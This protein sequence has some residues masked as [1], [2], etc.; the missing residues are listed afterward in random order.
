[1]LQ[2]EQRK[3]AAVLAADV[4]EYSRL[5]GRDEAGTHAR[6]KEHAAQ[7]LEPALARNGGRLVKTTG[8]GFFAEFP[9]AVDALTAGIEFQKAVAE[10]NGAHPEEQRIV[11][12]V[13]LHLGDL[14][15]DGDDL[16]GN[17]MN[18]AARLQAEAAPGGIVVSGALVEALAGQVQAELID[19]GPLSLKNI[20]WPVQAYRVEWNKRRRQPDGSYSLRAAGPAPLTVARAAELYRSAAAREDARRRLF[21][22]SDG[23]DAMKRELGIL[24][25]EIERLAK[26]EAHGLAIEVGF[27]VGRLGGR[28]VMTNGRVSMVLGWRSAGP[29]G[30]EDEALR[31]F[32]YDMRIA[33][34]DE[35]PR[36]YPDQPNPTMPPPAIRTIDYQLDL[37]MDCQPIWSVREAS[38]AGATPQFAAYLLI[39][40]LERAE[41]HAQQPRK[42]PRMNLIG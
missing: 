26:E 14:I 41:R 20:E 31:R 16:Y 1:M 27:S 25:P 24:F 34:P 42:P 38:E 13:G 6:L 39:Q 18:V 5:M 9:S 40:F 33:L 10:A 30:I 7:Y 28:L 23:Q 22:T 32:D 15:V 21:S 12:R 2:R 37:D 8:D 4:V 17:G 3:L 19:L 36:L 11:F 35:P 29:P